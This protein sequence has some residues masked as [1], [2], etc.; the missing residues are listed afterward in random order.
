MPSA[1][2]SE[3]EGIPLALAALAPQSVQTLRDIEGDEVTHGAG[4]LRLAGDDD[5]AKVPGVAMAYFFVSK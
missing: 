3:P 4:D 1:A 5:I 2:A